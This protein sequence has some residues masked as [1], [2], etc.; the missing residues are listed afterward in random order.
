MLAA[1][2]EGEWSAVDRLDSTGP[3]ESQQRPA[4][5][6]CAV[7][8]DHGGSGSSITFDFTGTDPQRAGNT[9]AVEAV[10]VSAVGFV[11]LTT[12][13]SRR[14]RPDPVEAAATEE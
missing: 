11:L 4:L 8:V 9:N 5:L 7:R 3:G 2:P 13:M 6:R 12:V 10:T 14:Q 1:L